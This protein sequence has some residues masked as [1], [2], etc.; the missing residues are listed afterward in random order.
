MTN[1]TNTLCAKYAAQHTYKQSG[2]RVKRNDVEAFTLAGFRVLMVGQAF[3]ESLDAVRDTSL[4]KH[5]FKRKINQID[6]QL[7]SEINRHVNQIA[8]SDDEGQELFTKYSATVD[9]VIE[10]LAHGHPAAILAMNDVI[11]DLEKQANDY[12]ANQG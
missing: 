8:F 4:N 9:K 6:Q 12:E 5:D 7:Q 1:P 3:I 11:D 10:F 2:K